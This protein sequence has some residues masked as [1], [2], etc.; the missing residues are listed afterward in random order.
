MT[1]D[2]RGFILPTSLLVLTLLTVMLTAA[3]VMTSAEYRSTDNALASTRALAL[4]QAGLQTYFA[5]NRSLKPSDTGDSVRFTYSGGYT[6][7]VA[8]KMRDMTSGTTPW[9]I[10]ATG[11]TTD[12]LLS[13]Q[14]T[15]RRVIGQM[16]QLNPAS[17]MNPRAALVALN[18][19]TITG[20]GSHPLDGSSFNTGI[21]C[22]TS[23][24]TN[25]ALLTV[26]GGYSGSAPNG[27]VIY[28]SSVASLYDS[29]HIDWPAVLA[30]NFTP[31]YVGASGLPATG[32]SD[33]QVGFIQG[34][35][36]IPANT[37][38]APRVGIL[39]VTGDVTMADNSWWAG[40]IIAGGRIIGTGTFLV[41]GYAIT[42]LNCAVGGACIPNS[43]AKYGGSTLIRE[44]R[45]STCGAVLGIQALATMGPVKNT[46]MDNWAGY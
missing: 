13:G 2:R 4:A 19:T 38:Y 12:P 43:F 17:L 41:Q 14:V 44:V 31:D 15:A 9:A 40:I 16:A 6:D 11:V 22:A 32:N 26:T 29:T 24:S 10:R 23:S 7:V 21:S 46:F 34:N 3:F 30:G 5:S 36:T 42:G 35:V 8:R 20:A 37:S 28:Q 39:V 1:A 25:S 33:W 45:W 27:G 18:G